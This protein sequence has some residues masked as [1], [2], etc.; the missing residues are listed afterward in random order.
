MSG[1]PAVYNQDNLHTAARLIFR[2][3]KESFD[4]LISLQNHR[5][6][7]P[8]LDA[9]RCL[10]D[11]IAYWRSSNNCLDDNL[12][13]LSDRILQYVY[14]ELG[15]NP[16]ASFYNYLLDVEAKIRL[17]KHCITLARQFKK[18]EK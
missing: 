6:Q 12:I 13:V 9:L 7:M 14:E 17:A 16:S 11:S 3:D 8:I 4:F 5:S 15:R 18:A 2:G 10:A 1:Y